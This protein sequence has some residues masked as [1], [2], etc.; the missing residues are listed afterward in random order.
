MTTLVEIVFKLVGLFLIVVA[1]ILLGII[2]FTLFNVAAISALLG[3]A[4]MI[5]IGPI[6][7]VLVVVAAALL[8]VVLVCILIIKIFTSNKG[9]VSWLLVLF[10]LWLAVSAIAV[11]TTLRNSSQI[12]I[13]TNKIS[14]S[15]SYVN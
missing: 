6:G 14:N 5:G 11:T 10:L 3:S 1:A 12:E 2:I 7:Y 4:S 13:V 8:T 15:G 9:F